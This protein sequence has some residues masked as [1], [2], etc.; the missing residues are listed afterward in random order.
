MNHKRA[1]II[2]EDE[3][4]IFRHDN[5]C[6]N[7]NDCIEFDLLKSIE[8]LS[9]KKMINIKK[10]SNMLKI[11]SNQ[12]NIIDCIEITTDTITNKKDSN[13]KILPLEK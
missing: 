8:R 12:L 13:W 1:I 4:I 9:E 2:T 11:K 6:L 10:L 7:G 5:N 3:Q